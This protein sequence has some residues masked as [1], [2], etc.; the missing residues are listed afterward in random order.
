M[1]S[2]FFTYKRIVCEL[3]PV[4]KESARLL[5]SC[6]L[7]YV[8]YIIKVYITQNYD[9]LDYAAIIISMI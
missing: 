7:F 1:I 6:A 4:C 2:K 8:D 9:Y 5:R 3:L